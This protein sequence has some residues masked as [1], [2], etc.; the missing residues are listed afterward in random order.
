MEG[1]CLT[2]PQ[3]SVGRRFGKS[4]RLARGGGFRANDFED[5]RPAG[6]TFPFERSAAIFHD[7]LD[8]V[9]H[10]TPLA[11]FRAICFSHTNMPEVERQKLLNSVIDGQITG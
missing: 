6:G 5:K 2:L 10:L 8:C 4:R 1:E 3:T 7:V 11:T 9:L